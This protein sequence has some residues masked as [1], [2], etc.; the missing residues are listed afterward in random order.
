MAPDGVSIHAARIPLGVFSVGGRADRTSDPIED[1]RAYAA[2][3]LPYAAAELL[4]AD[5]APRPGWRW[6]VSGARRG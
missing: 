4:A 6:S 5:S 3:P 2:P 1:Y